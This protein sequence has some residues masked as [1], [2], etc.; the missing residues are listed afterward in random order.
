[1]S[2]VVLGVVLNCAGLAQETKPEEQK[3][4]RVGGGVK[5]PRVLRRV[6]TQYSP[7]ARKKNVEGTVLLSIVINKEGRVEDV[8][9]VRSF[10]YGLDEKAVEC[11]RQWE[12]APGTKDGEPVAVQVNMQVSFHLH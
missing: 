7:E 12:F 11:A 6:A 5:P 8:K 10:G 3:V 2:A 1:V 9:V 4:Y